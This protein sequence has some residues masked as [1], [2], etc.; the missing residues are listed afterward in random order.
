M[1]ILRAF[2]NELGYVN[3]TNQYMEVAVRSFELNH[4]IEELKEAAR[5]VHLSISDLPEKYSIRIAKGYIVSVNSSVE[6]FL[7]A[8]RNLKG[9]PTEEV[10]LICIIRRKTEIGYCGL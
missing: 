5:N 10:K 3:A 7:T 4:G 8:F 9:N 1:N 6:S 2:Y